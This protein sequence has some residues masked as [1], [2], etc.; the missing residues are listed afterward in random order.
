VLAIKR[1]IDLTSI[2]C[3]RVPFQVTAIREEVGCG[4]SWDI[5]TCA[6]DPNLLLLQV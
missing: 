3:L 2:E 1:R 6:S 5:P 4:L